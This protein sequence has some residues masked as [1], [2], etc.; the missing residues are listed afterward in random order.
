MC[1][2]VATAKL[3]L[4]MLNYYYLK[5]SIKE[6]LHYWLRLADLFETINKRT[7]TILAQT[8]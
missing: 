6:L 5:Q 1:I 3:K 4:Y 7:V 2:T 8:C